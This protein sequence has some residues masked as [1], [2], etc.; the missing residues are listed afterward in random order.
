MPTQTP[1]LGIQKPLGNE[2]VNRQSFNTNWD[3]I[4][5][6]A[7]R[8]P[9]RPKS[10]TYNSGTGVIDVVIG[11]G[12]VNFTG[13]PV[14]TSSDTTYSIT[15]P[16]TN[17]NY[18]IFFKND[19][20]FTHN[21]DNSN[22]SQAVRVVQ[23]SVGASLDSITMTDLRS[24]LPVSDSSASDALNTHKIAAV[25]DHPDGSVTTEKLASGAVTS[26]K[27]ASGA[28]G[29]SQLAANA[30]IDTVIGNRTANPTQ[31]PASNGPGTLTQWFSWITNRIKAILG[32]SLNWWDTPPTTLT[33]AK[34]HMDATTD[35]HGATSAATANRLMMRDAN[36]RAKV[37]APVA[38]DDIARKDT[39]DAHANRTDNPHQVKTEQVNW[40]PPNS[41]AES[42]VVGAYPVGYTIFYVSNQSNPWLG[43]SSG[44]MMVE[45]MKTSP[46]WGTQRVTYY[47]N[48]NTYEVWQRSAG[49]NNPDT[50]QWGP[51]IRVDSLAVE[52]S[53][54]THIGSGGNAHALA[55]TSSAGFMS[56]ADKSKLDGILPGAALNR[57][58]VIWSD[59]TTVVPSHQLVTKTISLGV[60]GK[61]A[62]VY[63]Q[64]D[65]SEKYAILWVTTNVNDS[66][67]LSSDTAS[68][69]K[70][71]RLSAS[72]SALT[73]SEFSPGGDYRIHINSAY[74][75]GTNLI[76]TFE[77]IYADDS[78]LT[79]PR[80]V[81]DVDY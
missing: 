22:I 71:T 69:E 23:V 74:L 59:T 67:G 56:A 39:V 46:G 33:A 41:R 5:Q 79:I 13:T 6:E 18:Y 14:E 24:E 72:P 80:M 64:G 34:A 16:L 47:G 68:S 65:S 52:S 44:F 75:S 70:R 36:G 25:L 12:R 51:W 10:A 30:V 8:E 20:T 28:V 57:K 61:R 76:I 81:I 2:T 58:R 63:V 15:G 43:K 31:V 29:T 48:T 3:I 21:T 9:F 11:P 55:T 50:T 40:L 45:T 37:A 26:D 19:G 38:S 35:V 73:D 27:I 32:G 54:A 42:D 53:L 66:I 62:V 1:K 60:T 78:T 77:N 17:T 4:D 7:K 49:T